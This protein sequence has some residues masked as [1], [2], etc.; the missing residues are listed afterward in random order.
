MGDAATTERI[1]EHLLRI[2][3]DDLTFRTSAWNHLACARLRQGRFDEAARL[4]ADAVAQNP[5]PDNAAAFAATLE[6]ARAHTA[7]PPP[8]PP[9]A[10]AEP[11]F[12]LLATG[13]IGRASCRERG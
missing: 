2:A 9:V 1:A 8:P 11:V 3:A 10:T 4:A 12:A 5:L 6:R 13:E 7:A